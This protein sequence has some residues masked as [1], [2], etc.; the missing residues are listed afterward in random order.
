MKGQQPMTVQHDEQEQVQVQVDEEVIEGF[1]EEELE[2]PKKVFDPSIVTEFFLHDEMFPIGE[3][4]LPHPH[5]TVHETARMFF[6]RT[7]DWL[8]W[9][10][11]PDQP[12]KGGPPRFPNGFFILNGEPLEPKKTHAQARCYTL[13]DIERMSIA[14]LQ[15]NVMSPVAQEATRNVAIEV[16]KMYGVEVDVDT[17][18]AER[19]E[20]L[21]D[22]RGLEVLALGVLPEPYVSARRRGWAA[23]T[24]AQWVAFKDELLQAFAMGQSSR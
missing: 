13:A 16:A 10:Y 7:A 3:D 6:G 21:A 1:P 14:L 2:P 4:G 23:L 24:E 19:R 15:T 18:E 17:V 5:F 9:R 8:R 20:R 22:L 12:R 11:R